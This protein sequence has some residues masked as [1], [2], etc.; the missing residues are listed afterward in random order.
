M[1]VGAVW[2]VLSNFVLV[3]VVVLAWWRQLWLESSHALALLFASSLYHVCDSGHGCLRVGFN[4]L[5]AIDFFFAYLTVYLVALT[6]GRVPLRFK[7]FLYVSA[8]PPLLALVLAERFHEHWAREQFAEI[9]PVLV[10]TLTVVTVVLAHVFACGR[11]LSLIDWPDAFMAGLLTLAA[12]VARAHE[13][14][15][16]Y[17][18]MH[19]LWHLLLF[20]ALYF[21]IEVQSRETYL[22]FWKRKPLPPPMVQ[23]VHPLAA[24]NFIAF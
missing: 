5:R 1:N 2:L 12:V 4:A 23:F 17:A 18:V 10:I 24:R 6:L 13:D 16:S 11:N 3:P 19:G 9:T 21:V 8:I 15:E 7:I 20:A 14:G 22:L